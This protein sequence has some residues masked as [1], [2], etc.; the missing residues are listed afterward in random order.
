MFVE[1]AAQLQVP[2]RNVIPDDLRVGK[3]FK[4]HTVQRKPVAAGAQDL[5]SGIHALWNRGCEEGLA[6]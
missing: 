1:Y 6:D 5:A 3:R 4:I 2:E